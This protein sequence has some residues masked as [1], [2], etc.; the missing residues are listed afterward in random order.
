MKPR[1][2]FSTLDFPLWKSFVFLGFLKK[3]SRSSLQIH[4]STRTF[5]V[6]K[7]LTIY[8]CNY[9]YM[10]IMYICIYTVYIYICTVQ[11]YLFFQVYFHL[12]HPLHGSFPQNNDEGQ[13]QTTNLPSTNLA[14]GT[15]THHL[16]ID[17]IS[18]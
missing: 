7:T 11:G 18:Y 1:C 4:N 9:I 17:C 12:R 15:I 8:Y 13:K 5:P 14:Y 10:Y 2:Y 16:L 6:R 3:L